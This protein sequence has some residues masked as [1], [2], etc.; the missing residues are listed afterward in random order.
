MSKYILL[1]FLNCFSA[2]LHAN[3]GNE[4]GATITQDWIES[5]VK[6]HENSQNHNENGS[7]ELDNYM[8]FTA[9]LYTFQVITCDLIFDLLKKF[10]NEFNIK[11]I[12]L[13]I[14]TLRLVGFN[15]RKDDPSELRSIILDIQ[16]KSSEE[17]SSD[18][19]SSRV[20]FMLETLMAI[21]NNNVKKMPNYDPSHQIH[22]MKVMKNYIRPG[23]DLIPLKVRLE[24]LL[25]AET[26][27]KWW[28][29]GSA[30]SGRENR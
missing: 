7:K 12:E 1:K 11:N 27:G 13:I 14:L 19:S 5:M 4:V 20:K 18:L 26:R 22:L 30:W 21:K 16:K 6:I 10:V 28:I 2:L 29:V 25:Q 15:L 24:D 8:M 23:A 9:Y 17:S 3:I